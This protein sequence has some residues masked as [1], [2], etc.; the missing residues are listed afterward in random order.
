MKYTREGV[1]PR[2]LF[3]RVISFTLLAKCGSVSQQPFFISRVYRVIFFWLLSLAGKTKPGKN[4]IRR[5]L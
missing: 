2:V 3:T 5:K 1:L 4:H